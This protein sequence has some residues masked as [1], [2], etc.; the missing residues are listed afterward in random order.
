MSRKGLTGEDIAEYLKT[1]EYTII[2]DNDEFFVGPA[3]E[4]DE[5]EWIYG[6]H[7]EELIHMLVDLLSDG[8]AEVRWV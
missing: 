4:E 7:P 1:G 6:G 5:G 8:Q 3:S 2:L